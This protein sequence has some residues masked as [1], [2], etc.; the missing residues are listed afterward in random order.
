MPGVKIVEELECLGIIFSNKYC[1]MEDINFR[2]IHD[3][4]S[5][6]INNYSRLKY[7][8]IQ[9][10]YVINTYILSRIWYRSMVFSPPPWFIKSLDTLIRCYLWG[11][12]EKVKMKVCYNSI[13][14]GGL[15]LVNHLEVF[16]RQKLKWYEALLNEKNQP[17]VWI[18]NPM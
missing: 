8:L 9:R 7:N 10:V 18:R 4:I 3:K 16:A 11:A 5:K 6:Q 2:E 15:G 17:W 1:G 12:K 14:K 13:E